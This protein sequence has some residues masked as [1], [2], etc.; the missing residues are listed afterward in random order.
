MSERTSRSNKDASPATFTED[1]RPLPSAPDREGELLKRGQ[2]PFSEGRPL[3]S[4]RP[5]KERPD[6]GGSKKDK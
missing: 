3:P 1:K 5:P 2:E 4:P 6:R